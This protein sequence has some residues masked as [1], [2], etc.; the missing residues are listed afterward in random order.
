M[1]GNLGSYLWPR[2][3]TLG[4]TGATLGPVCSRLGEGQERPGSYCGPVPWP[5]GGPCW[6]P[7]SPE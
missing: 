4:Q 7:P 5:S 6:P 2:G 3:L 1:M